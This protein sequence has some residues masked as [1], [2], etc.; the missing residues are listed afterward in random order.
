MSYESLI[1]I[2]PTRVQRTDYTTAM[3]AWVVSL[4]V[5]IRL[6]ERQRTCL[7]CVPEASTS[8]LRPTVTVNDS[9]YKRINGFQCEIEGT[10]GEAERWGNFGIEI[11]WI[12]SEREVL[13]KDEVGGNTLLR[14]T[15]IPY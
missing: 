4:K 7:K 12:Q 13:A 1:S 8:P 5:E 9:R 2:E 11:K 3:I 6:R 14:E 15:N 10:R